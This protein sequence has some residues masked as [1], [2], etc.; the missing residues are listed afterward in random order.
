M[1]N[2]ES[3]EFEKMIKLQDLLWELEQSQTRLRSM[4]NSF[5][6]ASFVSSQELFETRV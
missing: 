2:A 1:M 5:V 4:V 3:V 6:P